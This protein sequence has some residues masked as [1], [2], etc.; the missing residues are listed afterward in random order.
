MA[1]LI[2]Q[3]RRIVFLYTNVIFENFFK[4]MKKDIDKTKIMG[5]NS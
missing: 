5:Y 2:T 1:G 3:V 4:K